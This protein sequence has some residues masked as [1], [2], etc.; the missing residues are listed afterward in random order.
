[1]AWG[2]FVVYLLYF[3]TH[4]FPY[5]QVF[6]KLTFMWFRGALTISLN[7]IWPILHSRVKLHQNKHL[8]LQL[9]PMENIEDPMETLQQRFHFL[10]P[11]FCHI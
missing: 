5:L 8:R 11:S 10:N 3:P 1:M 4:F 2:L 7:P 9:D 6:I